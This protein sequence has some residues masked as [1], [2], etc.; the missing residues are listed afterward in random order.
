ML[1]YSLE[2]FKSPKRSLSKS[3]NENIAIEGIV[4]IDSHQVKIL[5]VLQP[6]PDSNRTRTSPNLLI[7]SY[8][9]LDE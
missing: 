2:F 4:N 7:S 9:I 5:N 8:P 6:D 1:K 3:E